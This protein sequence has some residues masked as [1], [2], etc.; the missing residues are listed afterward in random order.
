MI[1]SGGWVVCLTTSL[2]SDVWGAIWAF[3]SNVLED[4]E[5][6][7]NIEYFWIEHKRV[8]QIE[9]EWGKIRRNRLLDFNCWSIK[10]NF[11]TG[12]VCVIMLLDWPR[13]YCGS[14]IKE[15]GHW[16][17]QKEKILSR[18]KGEIPFPTSKSFQQVVSVI[19]CL[20]PLFSFLPLTLEFLFFQQESL[21]G[22]GS[23]NP[24]KQQGLP[25]AT[26]Q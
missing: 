9:E 4:R 5:R 23:H 18:Q 7:T 21:Y 1:I 11:P 6:N 13:N 10:G 16:T 2:A 14:I 25:F 12:E 8:I 17:I 22:C 15:N 19:R 20:D 26:A 3:H 24:A